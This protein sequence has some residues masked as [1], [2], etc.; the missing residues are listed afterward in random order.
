M[1]LL[2]RD[3]RR[4]IATGGAGQCLVVVTVRAR[5][6]A[7]R[8]WIFTPCVRRSLNTGS[9]GVNATALDVM[10]LRAFCL[11]LASVLQTASAF[12]TDSYTMLLCHKDETSFSTQAIKQPASPP[13][14]WACQEIPRRDKSAARVPPRSINGFD[15]STLPRI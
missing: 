15:A 8:S 7:R 3:A 5:T 14:K 1:Q 2:V 9:A 6:G 10:A 4:P 12:F 13:P 11:L